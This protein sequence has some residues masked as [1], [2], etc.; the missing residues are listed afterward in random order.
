[1]MQRT[2]TIH[3]KIEVLNM[4]GII[5]NEITGLCIDGSISI[6]ISN[7]IRR[8]LNMTFIANKKLEINEQSLLWINKRL[9]IFVGIERFN[10]DIV[11]FCLGIYIISNPQTLFSKSGRTISITG[12]DKMVL[13]EKP[14]MN[15][16]I[17]PAKTP[18][19]EAI[20]L[21]AALVGENKLLIE[22]I[23]KNITYEI[24]VDPTDTI[25]KHLKDIT[26]LYMNY[27][28]Y[29]NVDGYLVYEK[30]KNKLN[31]PIE[32]EFK[33]N[34][35]FTISRNILSDYDG[36]KNRVKVIG[37]YDSTT[38]LQPKYE[39]SIT[40]KD[41]MFSIENIGE[42]SACF[43]EDDYT[44]VEQCR[45]KCE[46]EIEKAQNLERVFTVTTV[47]IF[48]LNDV[49]KLIKVVDNNIE[50]TCVIDKIDIPLTADGDMTITCHQIFK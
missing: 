45:L 33:E 41:K 44:T 22:T 14:F 43:K 36:I 40:G 4:N 12:N 8:T 3:T 32:W 42:H 29:Y 25:D 2:K 15:E 27:Q 11:W 20:K 6:D 48:V 19:H 9:R 16:C 47:P 49:N 7:L 30:T 28:T 26:N 39:I 31:D 34:K 38:G 37:A 10:K 46:Y 1:M 5:V 17:I 23:N 18:I 13:Y 35:N 50:Y 21:L 24:Q